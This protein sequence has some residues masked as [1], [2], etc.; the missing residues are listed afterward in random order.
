MADELRRLGMPPG[1]I[2][3]AVVFEPTIEVPELHWY[4][5]ATRALREAKYGASVAVG[6]SV[7]YLKLPLRFKD[8]SWSRAKI[9]SWIDER[10]A[11]AMAGAIAHGFLDK[12]PYSNPV[13]LLGPPIALVTCEAPNA[14]RFSTFD[15]SAKKIIW[16]PNQPAKKNRRQQPCR[17]PKSSL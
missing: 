1:T 6:E 3:S 16:W 4:K 15:L 10:G 17:A 9:K 14:L 8:G 7:D 2:L 12:N 11:L 5:N 13:E